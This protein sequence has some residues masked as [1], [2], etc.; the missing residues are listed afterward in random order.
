LNT[1]EVLASFRDPQHLCH[2]HLMQSASAEG[3]HLEDGVLVGPKC[4]AACPAVVLTG[5]SLSGKGY[6]RNRG[7]RLRLEVGAVDHMR[8]RITAAE[9]VPPTLIQ[10]L[11]PRGRMVLPTAGLRIRS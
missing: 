5:S 1:G 8:W 2:V 11:K 4:P 3:A 9:L 10:Q 7:C 6:R